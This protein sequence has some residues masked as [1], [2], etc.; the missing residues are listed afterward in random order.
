MREGGGEELFRSVGVGGEVGELRGVVAAEDGEFLFARL[1]A[2]AERE[3][4]A[5]AGVGVAR[6]DFAED[7]GG[8]ALG[9]SV[10]A[11]SL[12]TVSAWSGVS[13]RGRRVQTVWKSGA[14]KVPKSGYG[15]LR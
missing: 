12:A 6:G 10:K 1:A 13:E 2:E 3:G 4:A 7:A 8:E 11:G 5:D 9:E 14:S 15:A